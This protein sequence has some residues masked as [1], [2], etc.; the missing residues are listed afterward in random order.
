MKL[1]VP[2]WHEE[3]LRLESRTLPNVRNCCKGL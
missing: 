2:L 1:E 3:A